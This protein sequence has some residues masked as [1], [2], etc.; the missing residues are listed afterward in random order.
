MAKKNNIY[1]LEVKLEAIKLKE[2][3]F[4]VK[5]IQEL[6]NI[7]NE[8]QIYAWYY[9]YRDGEKERLSQSPGKQYSFGFGPTY[10]SKQDSLEAKNEMLENQVKILKKYREKERKWFQK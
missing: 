4:S 6:L 7:K 10:A 9:W 8:S 3:G 5:E 1:P 2:E